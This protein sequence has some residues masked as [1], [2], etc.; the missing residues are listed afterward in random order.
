M[1]GLDFSSISSTSMRGCS[2][3]SKLSHCWENSS[4]F[5]EGDTAGLCDS[6]SN[7]LDPWEKH[8]KEK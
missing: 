6:F 5:S 3:H 2:G 1:K 7:S 8:S 4:K